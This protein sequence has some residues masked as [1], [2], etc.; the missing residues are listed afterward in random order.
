[1]IYIKKLGVDFIKKH[2]ISLGTLC[3]FLILL[4]VTPLHCLIALVCLTCCFLYKSNLKAAARIWL[5]VFVLW[6][7]I[8]VVSLNDV[9]I[10]VGPKHSIMPLLAYIATANPPLVFDTLCFQTLVILDHIGTT[11]GVTIY[12]PSVLHFLHFFIY[13]VIVIFRYFWP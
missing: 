3:A 6:Y 10:I 12:V 9:L 1:M 2:S 4:M 11:L 5:N 13:I 7:L 8:I